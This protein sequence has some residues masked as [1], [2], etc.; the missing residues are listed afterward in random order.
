ME[1][2][3]QY[4]KYKHYKAEFFAEMRVSFWNCSKSSL[5][6]NFYENWTKSDIFLN[7]FFLVLGISKRIL[8]RWE[9]KDKL[10]PFYL[11]SMGL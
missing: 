3:T 6:Y 2:I 9:R 11:Y 7:H 10:Y 1:P 5:K 8:Y 4:F